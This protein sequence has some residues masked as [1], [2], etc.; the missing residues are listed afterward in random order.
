M[1][2]LD[3][4]WGNP[5]RVAIKGF[6]R[7]PHVPFGVALKPD[8]VNFIQRWIRYSGVQW[9][10]KRVKALKVWAIQILSGNRNFREDWFS[11]R[12]YKGYNIPSLELFK[13][14]VDCLGRD[15][16]TIKLI[17]I[18]LNS[19]KQVT[20][21]SPSLEAIVDVPRSPDTSNYVRLLMKYVRLP[22]VPEFAL[23]GTYA[24]P[25]KRKFCD[26]EGR[27]FP[28][29]IGQPDPLPQWGNNPEMMK[30]MRRIRPV[31]VTCLGR[32][33]PVRDKGK[34]RNI[35]VGNQ[36]LQLAVKRLADWLR[37]WLWEQA[38]VASGD[39]AK[40]EKFATDSLTKGK[41]MLSIDLS[42]ATDRLSRDFQINLL[43]AMGLPQ[44]YLGFLELPFFYDPKLYN[45]GSGESGL[46]LNQYSNGQPMGLYVSFPMF[47]LM[48]YVIL[49]FSVA[50]TGASFSICGDDVIVA[51]DSE[52]EGSVVFERYKNLIERLGGKISDAKTLKSFSAAE[53]VGALFLKGY[54]YGIRIPYGKLSPL[55]AFTK[56]TQVNSEIS[57]LSIIGRSLLV[58]WL[59]NRYTKEYTYQM[60][61]AANFE[62]VTR[63]L[64]HLNIQALRSLVKPDQDP[65]KY[66]IEDDH[67]YSFWVSNPEF[68]AKPIY[69]VIGMAKIRELLIDDK[70]LKLIKVQKNVHKQN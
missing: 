51:T 1:I 58:G 32:L 45:L 2:Y 68:E 12:T 54:P 38:E 21:G 6:K 24:I 64:S 34:W 17:L 47:E 23:E 61:R 20:L 60:R 43:T 42:E 15:L 33:V 44:G 10:G 65:I 31:E 67:H 40:M 35:L 63:D 30:I 5:R 14:L 11:T 57:K 26:N 3:T 36:I 7:P 52:A 29:P 39:Q 27:T 8:I 48:H 56:G 16:K 41:Y 18:V 55:E 59:S 28:G 46:A 4:L 70:I 9:T 25:S 22:R 53:G 50:T 49:K 37:N 66:T 13:L 62:L 69:R 19:Y